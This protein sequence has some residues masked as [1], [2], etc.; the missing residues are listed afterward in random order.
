MTRQPTLTIAIVAQNEA[1]ALDRL[2]P[3]LQWADEVLVVDGGSRDDTPATVVRHGGRLVGRP[4][5]TFSNQRNAALDAALG[6]W[7]LFVDADET[8]ARGFDTEVRRAIASGR[9]RAFRVP[10]RSRIFG[11]RFRYSGAQDDRPIRLVDR[12]AAR[13][14]G[15]VHETARIDGP[16]GLLKSWLDHDTMPNVYAFLAKMNRY[17]ALEAAARAAHGESP[18]RGAAWLAPIRETARRLLFKHGWLDGPSGWA[19]CLLSGL[20]E[21]VLARRHRAAWELTNGGR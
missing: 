13:W 7:V 16:S 6:D 17:T 10:I 1:L 19:F 2:L 12:R 8:P 20:S 4:F 18:R 3:R 5:D 14:V 9:R 11:R 21:W 15:D